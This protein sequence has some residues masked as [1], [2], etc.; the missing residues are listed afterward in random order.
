MFLTDYYYSLKK[1]NRILDKI[2]ENNK[3]VKDIN[4]LKRYIG[5]TFKNINRK[6]GRDLTLITCDGID[7]CSDPGDILKNYLQYYILFGYEEQLYLAK[8]HLKIM[9]N[10]VDVDD[11]IQWKE[12]TATTMSLTDE[13]IKYLKNINFNLKHRK[14]PGQLDWIYRNKDT[15]I[16]S[17]GLIIPLILV[18]LE[19]GKGS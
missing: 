5:L 18:L 9:L 15:I 16:Q 8:N 4:S 10:S 6:L 2:N 17:I 14:L 11:K 7:E 13:I 3:N 1:A 19:K 12:F